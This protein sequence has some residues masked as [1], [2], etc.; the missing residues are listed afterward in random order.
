MYP[1]VC[2]Y[3]LFKYRRYLG[4]KLYLIYGEGY[5][6]LSYLLSMLFIYFC[7]ICIQNDAA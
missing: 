5:Q 3:S 1:V 6:G 4:L 7:C 2:V